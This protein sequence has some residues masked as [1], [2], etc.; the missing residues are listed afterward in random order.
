MGL[1]LKVME[2]MPSSMLSD[3]TVL[4]V[5]LLSDQYGSQIKV[6]AATVNEARSTR[7]DDKFN[8]AEIARAKF[9][10]AGTSVQAG[11][12]TRKAT[13]LL[14]VAA[15]AITAKAELPLHPGTV[16]INSVLSLQPGTVQTAKFIAATDVEQ[17]AEDG[18]VEHGV[19][20]SDLTIQPCQS[21]DAKVAV[22]QA[23]N[24]KPVVGEVAKIKAEATTIRVGPTSPL[25]VRVATK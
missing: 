25:V 21:N 23:A 7:M 1:V 12:L 8:E 2:R 17:H 5:L 10:V 16:K 18:V 3:L 6:V 4:L 15:G 24:A 11:S 20:V 19:A 9:V 22:A 14:V 13:S